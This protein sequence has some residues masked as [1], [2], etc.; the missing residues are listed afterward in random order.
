MEKRT[1]LG[2]LLFLDALGF[3]GVVAIGPG[4]TGITGVGAEGPGAETGASAET[5]GGTGE[6]GGEGGVLLLRVPE[7]RWQLSCFFFS[8]AKKV[9]RPSSPITLR[10]YTNITHFTF[11]M[12]Q[13]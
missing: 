4:A 9:N 5:E 6:R 12:G 10:Q 1:N 8:K 2:F 3:A 13:G 11:T 7:R